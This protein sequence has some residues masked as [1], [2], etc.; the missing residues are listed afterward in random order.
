MITSFTEMLDLSTFSGM[1]MPKLLF[2]LRDKIFFV[3]LQTET[4]TPLPFSKTELF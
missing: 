2:H 3:T 1:T 4:M